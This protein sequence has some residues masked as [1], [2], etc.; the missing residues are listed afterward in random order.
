[1]HPCADLL[2]DLGTAS[3]MMFVRPRRP[4]VA[5]EEEGFSTPTALVCTFRDGTA[6]G[7]PHFPDVD[8]ATE[9]RRA[10]RDTNPGTPDRAC[11]GSST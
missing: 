11:R 10:R 8:A 2:S 1:M 6:P 3:S 5:I 9:S 7:I 4:A